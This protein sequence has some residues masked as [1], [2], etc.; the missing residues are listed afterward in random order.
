MSEQERTGGWGLSLEIIGRSV[1]A[2]IATLNSTESGKGR[3]RQSMAS[4]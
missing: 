4:T 3:S 2:A 1:F